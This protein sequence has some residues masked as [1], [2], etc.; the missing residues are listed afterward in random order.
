MVQEIDI[1]PTV[2]RLLGLPV[3]KGVQGMDLVPLM[4]GAT[5]KGYDRVYCELDDLPDKTY[6]DCHAIR[7]TDWKLEY[8]PKARRGLLYNLR[9]DPGELS[10]L[11]DDPRY[12][13]VRHSM[14]M[15]LLD[16]LFTSKDP[17]PIRLSQA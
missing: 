13:D 14:M 16:H 4:T 11:F 9:E 2:M 10:N 7:S 1:Y 15:D 12:S 6:V 3:H 5:A 17:L 8:F